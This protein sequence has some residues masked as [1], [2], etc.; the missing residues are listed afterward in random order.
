MHFAQHQITH[1]A[2]KSKV[3]KTIFTIRRLKS[4][5]EE[6]CNLLSSCTAQIMGLHETVQKKHFI[7]V[8]LKI[9]RADV[10]FIKTHERKNNTRTV[11]ILMDHAAPAALSAQKPFVKMRIPRQ[12]TNRR[13]LLWS[14]APLI[15]HR[16]TYIVC[17]RQTCVC[18][19]QRSSET[20]QKQSEGAE[21]LQ[22]R[23]TMWQT[24]PAACCCDVCTCGCWIES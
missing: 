18:A 9:K 14:I 16:K 2:L 1:Q 6:Q 23:N 8:W 4:I 15:L 10:Q 20:P 24:Q 3:C 7:V 11:Q 21:L 5:A 17:S 22:C 12:V 13:C 19:R